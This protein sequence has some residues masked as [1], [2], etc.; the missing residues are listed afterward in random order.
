MRTLINGNL[1]K[2]RIGERSLWRKNKKPNPIGEKSLERW[3]KK[4]ENSL[5]LVKTRKPDDR[6]QL[7]RTK[8]M[9]KHTRTTRKIPFQA[10]K[11]PYYK[12]LK[13]IPPKKMKSS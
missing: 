13:P 7:S 4:Y 1:T 6:N 12:P 2:T 5:G 8:S 10:T 11:P 3:K 9:K